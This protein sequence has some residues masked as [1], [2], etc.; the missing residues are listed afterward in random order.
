VFEL[1]DV[2]RKSYLSKLRSRAAL[3]RRLR[4]RFLI[5]LLQLAFAPLCVTAFT[6]KLLEHQGATLACYSFP[7]TALFS[8]HLMGRRFMCEQLRVRSCF[9]FAQLDNSQNQTRKL[10]R[11]LE[12]KDEELEKLHLQ[13]DQMQTR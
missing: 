12:E 1:P 3:N 6:F 9:R 11:V 2:D 13:L 10:T 5:P 8:V 4:N 7:R